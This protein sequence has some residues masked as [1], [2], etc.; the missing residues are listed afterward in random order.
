MKRTFPSENVNA[1]EN[2][3]KR[4]K[5]ALTTIGPLSIP[6]PVSLSVPP[7]LNK[8]KIEND[9]RNLSYSHFIADGRSLEDLRVLVQQSFHIAGITPR[10]H[11][12]DTVYSIIESLLSPFSVSGVWRNNFL[13]QH[14]AG[15]GKSLTIASLILF[16][17]FCQ[18]ERSKY[19]DT[20]LLL[21]D[22]K[23]LDV[24]LGETVVNFLAAHDVRH[25]SRVDTSAELN[26]ALLERKSRIIITTVQKF[27]QLSS[28][29]DTSPNSN[30]GRPS[31]FAE[32][33]KM[34]IRTL[35]S[36][37]IA[38][39]A[40]EA[41]RSHGRSTTGKLHGFLSG[42]EHQSS[43]LTYFSFTCTPTPK[44]LEMFG[45]EK[46]GL[47]QPFHTYS[48]EQSVADGVVFNVFDNYKA[49]SDFKNP[50]GS[51][52]TDSETEA[53]A[54]TTK[55][56]ASGKKGSQSDPA[57]VDQKVNFLISHFLKVTSKPAPSSESFSPKAMLVVS[58]RP[59]VVL[60]KQRFDIIMKRFPQDQRFEAVAAFTQFSFKRK[61]YSEQDSGVNGSYSANIIHA[62]KNPRSKV[63]LM[64]CA[65]KFQTGFDEPM[66][67]TMYIDKHLSDA[68]AVQTIS[69]I[70]RK[71][72]GKNTT[73]VIDFVNS[74]EEIE[75]SFS[76]Y[77]KVTTLG[78]EWR[79]PT[80]LRRGIKEAQRHLKRVGPF[81]KEVAERVPGQN[82]LATYFIFFYDI[83]VRVLTLYKLFTPRPSLEKTLWH[84]A[85]LSHKLTFA[86]THNK[87]KQDKDQSVMM[88]TN[89]K[90]NKVEEEEE[91]EE[92][93]VEDEEV[94]VEEG[95]EGEKE[96]GLV[97]LERAEEVCRELTM[98]RREASALGKIADAAEIVGSSL[99][100]QDQTTLDNSLVLLEKV[101]Y[102]VLLR[103]VSEYD[104]NLHGP[105]KLLVWILDNTLDT[106][107]RRMGKIT[108]IH[109]RISD[110]RASNR[111]A[112]SQDDLDFLQ[113]LAPL[114]S[115]SKPSLLPSLAIKPEP[116]KS[117][118]PNLNTNTNTNT[119]PTS[120]PSP[121]P[122]ANA[123]LN[124]NVTS[125][126][127]STSSGMSLGLNGVAGKMEN[128]PGDIVELINRVAEDA[129]K[130]P[131]IVEVFQKK[132]ENPN[133]KMS[134]ILKDSPYHPYF[135]KVLHMKRVAES[136]KKQP[137]SAINGRVPPTASAKLAVRTD[138]S[139]KDG[140]LS[141][142]S[143]T[144]TSTVPARGSA[145][146][147]LML[148]SASI[149]LSGDS[150]E[151]AA[152]PLDRD[153][154]GRLNSMNFKP[155]LS[156]V[157]RKINLPQTRKE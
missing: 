126:P 43:N 28:N 91:E 155:N 118:L 60:F 119:N 51:S 17:F 120:S 97:S 6:A 115:S 113:Q 49:V 94:E 35:N 109:V 123:N 107:S 83:F 33:E 36:L 103:L 144:S 27:A 4:L 95:Q 31:K 78:V 76:K 86:V 85:H 87:H 77:W 72:Q 65:D 92:E 24:Q 127:P 69:R 93:N 134:F 9:L 121:S 21:I 68:N 79:T 13:I 54:E 139:K 52:S 116:K 61:S 70:N 133:C 114:P 47:Y 12:V 45:I 122:K 149:A 30:S 100:E 7:P 38:I 15:S 14:S 88:D 73:Y 25:I 59:D 57:V 157:S 140:P 8:E 89:E 37:R 74:R 125:G 46:D 82:D 153:S 138:S 102:K 10:P 128:P 110:G 20:I 143:A 135:V 55:N 71:A 81:Q 131:S 141:T 96:T 18:T 98:L 80:D 137:L 104:P 64:I 56:R 101:L 145:S 23:E 117:V 1:Q 42:N 156:S 151:L 146:A 32:E 129:V 142:S 48:I 148:S 67:Q 19:F 5:G 106:F 75:D 132:I 66:I 11:Q 150:E 147:S 99:M 2:T 50:A 84:F 41:H 39:V 62:F 22:R 26:A 3:N 34:K 53:E 16:L 44:S 105:E 29:I 111:P 124:L 63:K 130:D 58:S 136:F 40:D 108:G 112:F 152:H 90:E 154:F